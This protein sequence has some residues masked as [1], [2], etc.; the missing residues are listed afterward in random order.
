MRRFFQ[1]HLVTILVLLLAGPA[2][3][4]DI[5]WSPERP[6]TSQDDPIQFPRD[7]S[8]RSIKCPRVR[9]VHSTDIRDEGAT[10]YLLKVDPWLGYQRGRELFLREFSLSDG[11]FGEPGRMAGR[12]LED[13]ATKIMTRDHVASCAMCHNVPFRDG[14]AGA[15]IFKNGGTGRNTPHLFG[16]GLIEMLGWQIRLKMLEKGDTNRNGFIDKGE[17][18][19]V[20]AIVEN[21]PGDKQAQR[22]NIDFGCFGDRDRDGK[23]DL[24]TVCLVWYVDKTGKRIPWARSLNDE[25]V[26]GYN[27]EVQV[28]GWGHGRATL[29]GRVPITSTLR[30]FSAQAFD[31][32]AGLQACDRTLNEE[33]KAD[34]L[35]LVSLPGAP[36][37]FTGRTRD[38]GLIKDARGISLDDPD[39]DGV[40]EELTEGDMD[41]VE[42]YQ[43]NHPSPAERALTPVRRRGR[44]VLTS[45]GCASCHVPDWRLEADNR[46]AEDYTHRYLGDRRFFNLTVTPNDKT[47]QLEGRLQWLT[48]PNGTAAGTRGGGGTV[49]AEPRREEFTIAGVYSDFLHH[50]L[51]PAF[52]QVQFDGSI[53]KSFRTAPLWGVGSTAPY[54]HDGA[55]LDLDAVIRRHGGEAQESAQ[56]YAGLPDS[57]RLALL[58]FL[59]G[60]VLYSVDD[61]PCDIDGDG[62]IAE[63]FIVAG[64]D[65][66]VERLNPEWLFRIPGRIEG[67]VTNPHGVKVRSFALTNVAEA[68]GTNLKYLKGSIHQGFPDIRFGSP[69][70]EK[71]SR[72]LQTKHSILPRARRHPAQNGAALV[73][74]TKGMNG[75]TRN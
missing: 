68:Y 53:I 74:L 22:F 47:A 21:M 13:Q 46:G 72:S 43:L 17:S 32:H 55:S 3:G 33:P 48:K 50:D 44:E 70:T 67:E 11:V 51:G 26:A 63:R 14:G 20:H 10:A 54:G 65:T 61:L 23:P 69:A 73:K 38:R 56:A 35:A 8:G 18:A 58:E 34:G 28:F 6:G 62:Q 2:F 52:H 19:D 75:P 24:N 57:D 15:T 39:R 66:G 31:N 9:A 45:I 59:R 7:L 37:F 42:F 5:L 27:F 25:G 29:A 49:P 30:A 40:L 1:K 64:Q 36:Q 60:L 12:V 4:G 41:L 16:A 71:Q